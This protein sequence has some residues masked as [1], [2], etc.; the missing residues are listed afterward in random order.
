MGKGRAIGRLP[1]ARLA[2][3]DDQKLTGYLLAVDHPVGRWKAAFFQRFGFAPSTL[4]GAL[5]SHAR[6]GHVMTAGDTI[7]GS[8]YMIEGR[9]T[10]PDGR[11]PLVRSVWFIEAG[12][13]APRLVTA[14]PVQGA[15]E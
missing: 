2:I 9:L 13:R 10:A 8:K 4:R 7:F 11:R 1:G 6:F 12:E 15:D 5:L 14:Y 3:I